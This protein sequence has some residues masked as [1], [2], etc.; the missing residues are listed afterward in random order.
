MK[1]RVIHRQNIS[2]NGKLKT[3]NKADLLGLLEAFLSSHD[4]DCNHT[5]DA[6]ILDGAA[7]VNMLPPCNS[8]T[9]SDYA[10][11]KF[12]PYVMNQLQHANIIDVVFDTYLSVSLKAETLSKR[13]KRRSGIH[14]GVEKSSPVPGN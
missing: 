10:D 9:F 2:D 5:V 7:I 4:T 8:S 11:Q 3:G 12:G 1:T 14:R 13:S 6:V